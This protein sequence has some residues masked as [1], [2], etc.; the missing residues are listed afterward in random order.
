MGECGRSGSRWVA[1][2][3]KPPVLA[4]AAELFAA[5]HAVRQVALLLGLSRSEAGRLRQKAV[6]GGLF[7]GDGENEGEDAEPAADEAYSLN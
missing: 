2:D 6:A 7:E 3:I 5:G 1:G 4:R